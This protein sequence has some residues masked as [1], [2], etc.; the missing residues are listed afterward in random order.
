MI[1][2]IWSFGFVTRWNSK[3]HRWWFLLITAQVA[4]EQW[5]SKNWRLRVLF[6]GNRLVF[7]HYCGEVYHLGIFLPFTVVVLVRFG[8]RSRRRLPDVMSSR[9]PCDWWV[10]MGLDGEIAQSAACHVAV[11]FFA[12][13]SAEFGAHIRKWESNSKSWRISRLLSHFGCR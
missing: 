3:R 7:A 2:G 11:L 6:I 8:F 13:N 1:V 4:Q 5:L 9:L 10:G 12:L